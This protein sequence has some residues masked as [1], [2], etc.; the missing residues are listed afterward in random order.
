MYFMV[1]TKSLTTPL[2][3]HCNQVVCVNGGVVYLQVRVFTFIVGQSYGNPVLDKISCRYRGKYSVTNALYPSHCC[4][5]TV[6][7]SVG[8]ALCCSFFTR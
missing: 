6:L 4:I 2:M 1:D 3:V 5:D 7:D 8:E